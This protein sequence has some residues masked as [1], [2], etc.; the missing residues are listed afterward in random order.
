MT[1]TPQAGAGDSVSQFRRY[2][3]STVI[4]YDSYFPVGE[5]FAFNYY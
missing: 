5:Q 3:C 1:Q 2:H 4:K